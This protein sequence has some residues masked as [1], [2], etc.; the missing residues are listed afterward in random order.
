MVR[1]SFITMLICCLLIAAATVT[2]NAQ[3]VYEGTISSTYTEIAEKINISVSDDYVFFRSGQYTYTLVCGD[4]EYSAGNFNL[5][6]SGKMYTITQVNG[7]GYSASYYSYAVS[8]VDSYTIETG[9]KLVYSNLAGY[10]T[11]NNGSDVYMLCCLVLLSVL[12]LCFFIRPLFK[13]T[14]RNRS[15]KIE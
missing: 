12:C 8:D 1:K 3:S 4:F 7:T 6:G 9:G 10:P 2:A 5:S 15:E 11:L 13:F 14:M